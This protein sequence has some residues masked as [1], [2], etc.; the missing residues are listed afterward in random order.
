MIQGTFVVIQGT[1]DMIQG[2]FGVIQGTL[3]VITCA[4]RMP[5]LAPEVAHR[6]GAAS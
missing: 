2:T 3:A 4:R 1:F 6:V 5:E